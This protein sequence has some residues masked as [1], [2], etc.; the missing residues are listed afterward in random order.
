[1]CDNTSSQP[2]PDYLKVVKQNVSWPVICLGVF[3]SHSRL[4]ISHIS[5]QPYRIQPRGWKKE[6]TNK[7]GLGSAPSARKGVCDILH[8]PCICRLSPACILRETSTKATRNANSSLTVFPHC[9]LL[10]AVLPLDCY[11]KPTVLLCSLLSTG[12]L[13]LPLSTDPLSSLE[14]S[15]PRPL[16]VSWEVSPL[17]LLCGFRAKAD[18]EILWPEHTHTQ[19]NEWPQCHTECKQMTYVKLN[20]LK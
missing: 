16:P 14:P 12:S 6:Q 1:M 13:C 18:K 10:L 17:D 8:S 19:H 20:H 4:G 3:S 2:T 11:L 15:F 7:H 9:L 5:L